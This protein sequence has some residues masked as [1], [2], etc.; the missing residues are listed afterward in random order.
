MLNTGIQPVEQLVNEIYGRIDLGDPRRADRLIHVATQC[1]KN[2]GKCFGQ[3]FGSSHEAKGAYRLIENP[4]FTS[5][6]L[7]DPLEENGAKACL[8]REIVY[9]IQDTTKLDFSH[10]HKVEGLGPMHTQ[11]HPGQGMLLHSTI[12]L[13]EQGTPLGYLGIQTWAR[14]AKTMGKRN[15]R[16]ILPIEEKESYKWI[17]G[18]Q[19]AQENLEAFPDKRPYVIHVMD[20]EG[21]V[22]EV[23]EKAHELGHGLVVRAAWDRN[24]EGDDKH[25]WEAMENC[26]LGGDFTL[27]VAAKPN[28]SK[29]TARVEIRWKQVSLKPPQQ[30]KKNKTPIA[31][32]AV[33]VIEP[34]PPE[35]VKP[36]EWML[37][38]T[39]EVTNFEDAMRIV[40]IYRFRWRVED[41]HLILKSGCRI[42]KGQFDSREAIE[43]ILALYLISALRILTIR[44]LAETQPD[45]AADQVLNDTEQE[46][47]RVYVLHHFN[48]KLKKK[49]TV[50][51]VQMWIGRIGGHLGRKSDGRPGVRTLWRGWRDFEMIATM[52]IAMHQSKTC[53]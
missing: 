25:L 31:V 13:N 35:G 51:E 17:E 28:Q 52:F 45:C 9:A 32:Y 24:V 15:Q 36:I 38:T 33:W 10:R 44:Y 48:H 3:I 37:L 12:A 2:P 21:D 1:I 26:A 34:N 41:M 46:A 29:R 42:E 14:D 18:M 20:R 5:Q 50:G 27:T 49:I 30:R 4:H 7:F 6:D 19:K 53:G 8:E 16:K 40:Q 11:A 23:F 22:F 43:K 39:E 47:L